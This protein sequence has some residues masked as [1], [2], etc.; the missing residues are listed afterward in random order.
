ML[1]PLAGTRLL[2]LMLKVRVIAYTVVEIQ[3]ELVLE[4]GSKLR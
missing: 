3:I 4:N 2:S 1:Q